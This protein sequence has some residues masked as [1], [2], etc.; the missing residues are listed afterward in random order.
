VENETF[1]NPIFTPADP[2]TSSL[3]QG[4]VSTMLPIVFP[5]IQPPDTDARIRSL[6][7]SIKSLEKRILGDGIRIKSFTFQSREDL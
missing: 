5:P 4:S 7:H 1:H 2:W 6:E 3:N